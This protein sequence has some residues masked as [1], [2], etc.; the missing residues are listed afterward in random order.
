MG[1]P[2]RLIAQLLAL[3]VVVATLGPTDTRAEAGQPTGGWS[4]LLEQ[5]WSWNSSRNAQAALKRAEAAL[6]DQGGWRILLKV[7]TDALREAMLIELRD[8]VRRQLREERVAFADLAVREGSVEVRIR[9]PKDRERARGKL[10]T[11]LE[12]TSPGESTLDIADT[13]DGAL[14]LRPTDSGF[15][16]RLRTLRRQSVEVIERRLQGFGVASATVYPEGTDAIRLLLPGIKDGEGVSAVLNKKA[17]ITFR[18]VDESMTEQEALQ[19]NP[20]PGSEILY[21]LGDKTPLLLRK[22]VA[23]E[24][25]EIADAAP[26]FDQRTN[27]PIVTFRFNSKGTRLF[28]QITQENVGRPFAIVLDSDVLSVPIIREPILGGSGQISGSFT[29]KEANRIAVLLRSGMLPGRLIVGEQQRVEPESKAAQ[30]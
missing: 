6:K 7:D 5:L 24:G 15:A 4:W 30:K 17:R 23:M 18:L 3:A 22:Q 27:E 1:R 14:R 19:G 13:G 9:E 12:T 10:A 26:G 11:L 16:D 8:G 28:A 25:E 20:P 29:V 21:L 2:S